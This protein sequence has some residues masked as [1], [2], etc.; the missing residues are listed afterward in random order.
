MPY[1]AV[2]FPA[3]KDESLVV[4]KEKLPE[5]PCYKCHY[6][7]GW[8]D[9]RPYRYK[10]DTLAPLAGRRGTASHCRRCGQEI[11]FSGAIS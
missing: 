9:G 3:P 6:C 5:K 10:E 11:G 4:S 8:I 7:D 1:R 2:W